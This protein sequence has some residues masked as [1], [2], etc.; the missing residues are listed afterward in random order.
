MSDQVSVKPLFVF[1][2]ANNHGGSVEHGLTIIQRIHDVAQDFRNSFDFGFK[3]QYRDLDTFIHPEFRERREFK[4]ISRFLETRLDAGQLKRLKN[5]IKSRGFI[6]ICTPYDENSVDLAEQHDF[7]ML[8]ISSASLT[9]WPLLER[10]VKSEKPLIISTGGASLGDIDK[11]VSFF[12]HRDKQFSLMHC[13][14]LYPTPKSHLQLNQIDLLKDRYRQLRIG[15]STHEAPDN[16]D[17]VKLAMAKGA[18]ILEKHVGVPTKSTKLNEYS[19]TP[20]QVR[21]WLEA[22]LEAFEMCGVIGRRAD[23][24]EQE[25]ASLL[26]L[27][28]GAFAKRQ[29]LKDEKISLSDLFLAIPTTENQVTANDLSKYRHFHASVNIDVNQPILSGN[30]RLI[31]IRDKVWEIVQQIKAF[32]KESKV[33]IQPQLDLE[34]SYHYGI[35]RF[36]DFGAAI[37]TYFNRAYCRKLIIL[38]PGQTHPEQHHKVK[39]ESFVVLYGDVR[40]NIEGVEKEYK[41]G[42][43]VIVEKGRKHSFGSRN[44]AVIEEIST[45]HYKED[46]YYTDPAINKNP[47][48]KTLLTFWLD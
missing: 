33:V 32:L 1:E 43:A 2:M 12:E 18:T 16:F 4:Y 8:K 39:E 31:D 48:R 17:A 36:R 5:E 29:I 34:I 11:V 27:R 47:D 30:T 42:D 24:A 23:P 35:D 46:S 7:D 22:A 37:I 40:L 13:V 15:Y 45:T 20:E 28:R 26:S 6:A 10:I 38:L 14:A 25:T 9:D 41:L 21:K 3:L 44:G 19:A